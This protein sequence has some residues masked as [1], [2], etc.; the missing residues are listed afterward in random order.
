MS[1]VDKVKQAVAELREREALVEQLTTAELRVLVEEGRC[2]DCGHLE[3]VHVYMGYGPK[4]LICG[5]VQ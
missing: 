4:C 1:L 5:C 2:D 3:C